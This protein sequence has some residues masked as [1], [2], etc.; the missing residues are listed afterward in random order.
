M[1]K[2]RLKYWIDKISDDYGHFTDEQKDILLNIV[3][4]QLNITEYGDDG[5]MAFTMVADVDFV[6]RASLVVFYIVP[7]KRGGPL[8]FKML[9]DFEVGGKLRGAELLCVGESI[10]GYKAEKFNRIF[11]RFG[12]NTNIVWTKKV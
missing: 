2:T 3:C 7:E 11:Q 6:P 5:L 10:S 8:F 1:D 12:Y 9:K 4:P